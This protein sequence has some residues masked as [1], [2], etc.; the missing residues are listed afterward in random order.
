MLRVV[1]AWYFNSVVVLFASDLLDL[2]F[3]VVRGVF[4]L[5]WCLC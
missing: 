3:A 2:L 4:A 1:W 5:L